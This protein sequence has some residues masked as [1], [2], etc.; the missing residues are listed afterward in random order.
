MDRHAHAYS[1]LISQLRDKV[2]ASDKRCDWMEVLMSY[3]ASIKRRNVEEE[4]TAQN[5][6][7]WLFQTAPCLLYPFHCK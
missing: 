1:P 5:F 6:S 3:N 2:Q 4:E 7:D